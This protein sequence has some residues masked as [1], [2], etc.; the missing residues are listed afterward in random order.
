MR[1]PSKPRRSAIPIY[2]VYFSG[3]KTSI[4]LENELAALRK[5][6]IVAPVVG[7]QPP[8]PRKDAQALETVL[9]HTATE[10][11][12]TVHWSIEIDRRDTRPRTGGTKY[13][14]QSLAH[15]RSHAGVLEIKRSPGRLLSH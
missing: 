5:Q 9:P 6:R 13:I 8:H 15:G 14:L 3:F 7:W 2:T 11:A 10:L 12:H 1:S 4:S